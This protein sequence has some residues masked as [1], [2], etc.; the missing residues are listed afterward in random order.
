MESSNN[1]IT[2]EEYIK[3]KDLEKRIAMK[4]YEVL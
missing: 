4:M 2:F 3:K 1:K